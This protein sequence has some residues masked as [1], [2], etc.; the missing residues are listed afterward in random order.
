MQ[1][2]DILQPFMAMM[3]LTLGVWILFYVKRISYLTKH[4]VDPQKLTTPENAAS[5]I[6]EEIQNPSNNFRNLLELPVLFY[7]LCLYLFVT[8]TVDALYVWTAWVYV[9]LRAVHSIIH[10]TANVVMWRFQAF[11]ASSLVLWFMVLR[12]TLQLLVQ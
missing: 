10:C 9:A 7:A 1:G 11:M 4:R 8:G 12:A 6:P 3:L 5:I 2:I